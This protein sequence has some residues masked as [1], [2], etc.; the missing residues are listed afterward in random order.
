MNSGYLYLQQTDHPSQLLHS[1]PLHSK[2]S[3]SILFHPLPSTHS[4]I[5]PPA[6][7][8]IHPP[9]KG[10]KTIMLEKQ[11]SSGS[12]FL[13]MISSI[14]IPSLTEPAPLGESLH[15]QDES[16]TGRTGTLEVDKCICICTLI[17][18]VFKVD[19]EG[20]ERGKEND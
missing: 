11:R 9:S 6:H 12:L 10:K 13:V 14:S 2:L 17:P 5:H 8:S 1:T 4:L 7:P 16:R 18:R 19:E 3:L 20:K 15:V